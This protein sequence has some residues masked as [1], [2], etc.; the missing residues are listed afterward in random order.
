MRLRICFVALR[1]PVISHPNNSAAVDPQMSSGDKPCEMDDEDCESYSSDAFQVSKDVT[2]TVAGNAT[3]IQVPKMPTKDTSTGTA[4]APSPNSARRNQP[5]NRF[6]L[7]TDVSQL[8]VSATEPNQKSVPGGKRVTP[9]SD[10]KQKFTSSAP[11]PGTLDSNKSSLSM[12]KD[13][14]NRQQETKGI[15]VGVIVGICAAIL[16]VIFV[17]VFVV[18]KYRSRDEGSYK[19]DESRNYGY[20]ACNSKPMVHLNGKVKSGRH[21]RKD[22]EWYV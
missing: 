19:I 10:A 11:S 7:T 17:I 16:L 14:K 21:K 4:Y 3:Y 22:V 2:E 6:P 13:G 15:G 9:A 18:Y 20:E 12:A 5:T 1:F 8:T